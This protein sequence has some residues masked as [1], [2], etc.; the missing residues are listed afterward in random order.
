[1]DQYRFETRAKMKEQGSSGLLSFNR[2]RVIFE[3]T[4]KAGSTVYAAT[5][6]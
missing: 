5:A 4:F 2:E 3:L 6:S 1:M